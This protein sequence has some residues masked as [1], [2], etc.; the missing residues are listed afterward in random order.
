MLRLVPCIHR[1]LEFVV[2]CVFPVSGR[3]QSS[4]AKHSLAVIIYLIDMLVQPLGVNATNSSQPGPTTLYISHMIMPVQRYQNPLILQIGDALSA[5]RCPSPGH[6]D[7]PY[8]GSP[9][10]WGMQRYKYRSGIVS[11]QRSIIPRVSNV[12]R[13]SIAGNINMLVYQNNANVLPLR[14][15]LLEA[16]FDRR[17]VCLVVYHQE[18]LLRIR[19]RDML[20][21]D[22]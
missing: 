4:F 9:G 5:R 10:P 3:H 18:V 7:G 11:Y 12:Q 13:P 8:S 19:G 1:F 21:V 17:I 2:F 16:G 15:E 6:T 14:R 20:S 22:S